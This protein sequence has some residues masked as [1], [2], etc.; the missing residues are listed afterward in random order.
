MKSSIILLLGSAVALSACSTARSVGNGMKWTYEKA[1][2]AL[3]SGGRMITHSASKLWSWGGKKESPAP[4]TAQA[5]SA[6]SPAAAASAKPGAAQPPLAGQSANTAPASSQPAAAGR[7][8]ATTDSASTAAAQPAPPPSEP[9]FAY[10]KRKLLVTDAVLGADKREDSDS[11]VALKEN[12][13]VQGSRLLYVADF[14]GDPPSLLRAEGSPCRVTGIAQGKPITA[15]AREIHYRQDTGILTLKGF[16]AVETSG[17]K[18]TA[19]HGSTII[20]LRVEDGAIQCE[21]PIRTSSAY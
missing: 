9:S 18:I 11:K 8:A 13:D 7:S 2:D 15:Q 20:V 1:S 6:T 5:S 12:W 16:P 3:G 4:Q 17:S 14:A 19:T 21:G 10:D